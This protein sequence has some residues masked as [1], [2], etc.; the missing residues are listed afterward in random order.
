MTTTFSGEAVVLLP[1]GGQHWL[2]STLTLQ[3]AVLSKHNQKQVMATLQSALPGA[4][5]DSTEGGYY[6]GIDLRLPDPTDIRQRQQGFLSLVGAVLSLG[7]RPDMLDLLPWVAAPLTRAHDLAVVTQDRVRFE[8]RSNLLCDAIFSCLAPFLADPVALRV[9][10]ASGVSRYYSR[11]D[12]LA[13]ALVRNLLANTT[14]NKGSMGMV[15]NFPNPY[16]PFEITAASEELAKEGWF[17]LGGFN[18][19]QKQFAEAERGSLMRHIS[20]RV[21]PF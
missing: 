13:R 10:N 16:T 1:E 14:Q 11:L 2:T 9:R 6:L 4:H 21:I 8:T 19:W 20:P 15:D 12:P 3:S 18:R 5:L 17:T 7:W